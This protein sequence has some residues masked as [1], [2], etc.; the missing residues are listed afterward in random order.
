MVVLTFTDASGW[1][2]WLDAHHD[3]ETEAWLRIGKR[4]ADVSLVTI[5]EAGELA[6]CFGWIDGHRKGCDE[7]SFLQRF[8]RRRPRSPWSKVNVLRVESLIAAGRMRSPGLAEVDAARKGGRWEAAYESQ[9]TA[10]VPAELAAALADNP[11]ARTAFENLGRS[12]Q[13]ALMLP[14]LK[15]YTPATLERVLARLIARLDSPGSS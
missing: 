15:A 8:S 14:L 4:H 9:R 7:V 12:D 1:E 11:R 2:S 3:Q 13:Y 6:L 5:A 10:R